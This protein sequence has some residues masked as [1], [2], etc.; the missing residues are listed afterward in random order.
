MVAQGAYPCNA[1][2]SERN[3]FTIRYCRQRVQELERY[4]RLDSESVACRRERRARV[5]KSTYI[6]LETA[7]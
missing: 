5:H 6:V 3:A 2:L 1:Q 7:G 4:V